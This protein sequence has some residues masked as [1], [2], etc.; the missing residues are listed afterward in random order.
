MKPDI[1]QFLQKEKNVLYVKL[2]H[3]RF[4]AVLTIKNKLYRLTYHKGFL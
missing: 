2:S 4:Q 1:L 3:I